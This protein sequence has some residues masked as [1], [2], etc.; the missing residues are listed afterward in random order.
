[1]N[2]LRASARPAR[3][4]LLGALLLSVLPA[5]ASALI[6]GSRPIRLVVLEPGGQSDSVARTFEP[7][8]EKALGRDIVVENHGGAGGRI[9]ARLVAR[10]EPDGMTIGVGGA[11]NL[12]IAGLLKRDIGYDPTRDFTYIAALV[13]VPF[14]VGVRVDLGVS[15]LAELIERARRRPGV[16][17]YGTA[18]VGGSSHLAMAAIEE[19]FG[20][21]LLHVP[22]RGSTQA[23][24]E[25]AAGRIDIVATDLSQ[26]LAL[27]GD[28]KLCIIAA[29]GSERA[30]A[31]PEVPT[32]A[33]QG[34]AGFRLEPW[35][36]L[37]GPAGLP[38]EFAQQLRSAIAQAQRDP[39][40]VQRIEF[41][42]LQLLPPTE[43]AL[44]GLIENDRTRYRPLVEKLGL[45][46]MS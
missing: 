33:E 24:N 29:T 1:M 42:G 10:A 43:A 15:T 21:E 6:G 41:R 13:S 25:L 22:F 35:Y 26:L 12:V 20:I 8:L 40:L 28:R 44:R 23:L 38:E 2:A 11:N 46:S 5:A 34:M 31:M 7:T 14:A 16:L 27:A 36:G 19:F 32:L 9:G 30:R 3:R 45:N 39:G 18:S 4:R 37:Y 17:T